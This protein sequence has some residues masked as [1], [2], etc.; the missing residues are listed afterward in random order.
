[1]LNVNRI[2]IDA[3]E[4][5]HQT[6]TSSPDESFDVDV[7]LGGSHHLPKSDPPQIQVLP[8]LNLFPCIRWSYALKEREIYMYND[9]TICALPGCL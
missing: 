6:G 7:G 5:S 1:M 4:S 8:I 9:G 2:I 3:D